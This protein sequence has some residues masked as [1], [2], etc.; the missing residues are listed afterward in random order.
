MKV[1]LDTNVIMSGIFWSGPPAKILDAWQNKKIDLILSVDILDE[2]I[3]VSKVLYKKYPKVKVNDIID[4]LI[5][6][7]HIYNVPSLTQSISRD[8]DDDK[9]IACAIA[10]G[11]KIIISGD[12]DLLVINGF[13]DILVIKPREFIDKYITHHS[14]IIY[15]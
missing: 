4:L 1:I 7:S 15:A 5:T 6:N 9:F 12:D 8:K 14:D 2:Y 13:N 11:T 10:S 3:R